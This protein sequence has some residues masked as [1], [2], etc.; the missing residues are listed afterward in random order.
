MANRGLFA[1]IIACVVVAIFGIA[2]GCALPKPWSISATCQWYANAYLYNG[3]TNILTDVCLALHPIVMLWRVLSKLFIGW[4]CVSPWS[5]EVGSCRFSRAPP[6]SLKY[7]AWSS[8]SHGGSS[9]TS[10]K[11]SRAPFLVL[12]S[13][14]TA[15]GC[16]QD[17]T[18]RTWEAV[19]PTNMAPNT[20]DHVTFCHDS[21]RGDQIEH[22]VC[23]SKL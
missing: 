17:H 6:R 1:L 11:Y 12:P 14:T 22:N 9:L 19:T 3:I 4:C 15:W 8:I 2:F 16:F 5:S 23:Y 7:L 10:H 18:D 21:E 20:L 13:I